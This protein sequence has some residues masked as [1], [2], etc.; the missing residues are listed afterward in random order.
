MI[1]YPDISSYIPIFHG[2]ISGS[3]ENSQS[4]TNPLKE[5][6]RQRAA[7][8]ARKA[9]LKGREKAVAWAWHLGKFH[10]DL[11]SRPK[12]GNH[13]FYMRNHPLLWPQD[14]DYSELL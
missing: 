13:G 2:K 6:R 1:L 3:W 7:R 5:A 8:A 14:S 10:H 4:K 9:K 11:T 12:P